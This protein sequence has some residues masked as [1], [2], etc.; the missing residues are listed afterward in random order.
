[1]ARSMTGFG[2]GRAGDQALG[3][4]AEARSV[5]NRFLD[6]SLR[7]PRTLSQFEGEVRDLVR[8]RVERGRVTL[9][10]T[11]EWS[12][13]STGD[14]KLDRAKAL[15]YANLL[16]ELQALTEVP[17]EVRLEHLLQLNDLFIPAS[18]E[19]YHR[20][21]WG[22]AKEAIE[23]ALIEMNA[24]Q[25][26][27]GDVLTRDML[28]RI[29]SIKDGAA[30]IRNLAVGQTAEYRRR[31]TARLEDMLGDARLDRTRLENEIAIAADRLDISEEIVRLGSHLDLFDSTLKRDGAVG[32]TLGFV[33]QEMGREVNTIA[34]KSW[35]VEIAQIAV[36]MKETLEQVREQ[37]QNIE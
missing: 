15:N 6:L 10:V 17:G 26:R 5:N 24:S 30:Q 28:E 4:V 37:V 25:L 21:L 22:F 23:S 2:V 34:S 18:D 33:L 31:L 27:E 9:A 29:A 35:M 3:I 20:R 11:E 13:E 1:M 12:G 19:E 8:K 36:G 32:K 7:L 16:R 14:V